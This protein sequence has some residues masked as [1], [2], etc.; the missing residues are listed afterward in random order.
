MTLQYSSDSSLHRVLLCSR[1]WS[2]WWES[3][4][5]HLSSN[6]VGKIKHSNCNHLGW[7]ISLYQAAQVRVWQQECCNHCH[8][9]L[10]QGYFSVSVTVLAIAVFWST[11]TQ[12]LSSPIPCC[13]S[14]S[15]SP[16][17]Q[18]VAPLQYTA[19]NPTDLSITPLSSPSPV[20]VRVNTRCPG[21]FAMVFSGGQIGGEFEEWGRGA[22]EGEE[23]EPG[24]IL[25]SC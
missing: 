9:R 8:A 1:C 20:Q 14:L 10:Q 25:R 6:K 13:P 12:T 16:C 21:N 24:S 17:M 15:C 2:Q 3:E 22:T 4:A 11:L 23:K 5:V 19:R 7:P 18:V